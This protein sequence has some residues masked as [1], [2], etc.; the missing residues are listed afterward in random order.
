MIQPRPDTKTQN[1]GRTRGQCLCN[2]LIRDNHRTV[3]LL[4]ALL[5]I[6]TGFSVA[7]GVRVAE[8]AIAEG[9]GALRGVWNADDSRPS[10]AIAAVFLV[11]TILPLALSIMPGLRWAT[12]PARRPVAVTVHRSDRLRQ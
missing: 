9:E 7:D 6:L 4:L 1:I 10:V 8:P 3:K 11:A 2:R 5:A 12:K